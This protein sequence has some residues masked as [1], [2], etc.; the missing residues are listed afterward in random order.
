MTDLNVRN[1][2]T[3]KIRVSSDG[4]SLKFE[5]NHPVDHAVGAEA[6]GNPLI[7]KGKN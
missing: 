1:G 4:R 3:V 5:E 2:D 7:D 6:S